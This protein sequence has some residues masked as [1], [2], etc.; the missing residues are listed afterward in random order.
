[1]R[2]ILFVLFIVFVLAGIFLAPR[3]I[4]IS[5]IEC[6]SQFGKCNKALEEKLVKTIQD[7]MYSVKSSI[8]I[9]LGDDVTIEAFTI[10]FQ[11]PDK[12]I[13]DVLEQKGLFALKSIKQD[14]YYLIDKNG[15]VVS[16]QENSNLPT[17]EVEEV[18]YNVGDT[19]NNNH[20]FALDL[21][22]DLF[23][24][25]KISKGEVEENSL[26]IVLENGDLVIFPLEGDSKVLLGSLSLIISRLKD[27]VKDSK[28]EIA[29]QIIEID[30]RYNNPVVK[31]TG[32]K[33]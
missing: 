19:I 13:V 21:I 15:V 16:I 1:M 9:I 14:V 8:N 32:G 2:K 33:N 22:L 23:Y 29:D 30:L 25:Y 20:K 10:K 18:I 31:T 5:Q 7:D 26:Y 27:E 28:I 6:K 4:N 12:L 3:F 11:L 24:T 17:V